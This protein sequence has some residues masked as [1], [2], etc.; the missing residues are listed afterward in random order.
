MKTHD[1]TPE[2]P[3]RRRRL[4]IATANGAK[5]REFRRMLGDDAY[6]WED[7]NSLASVEPPEET[8]DTFEANARLKAAYYA[9]HAGMHALADDSGLEVDAL[10]GH[11]GVYS[12]RWAEIHHTGRG[13]ADN[14][15]LLLNQ[16][17]NVADDQRTARFV[18]VLAL[19]DE[20]GA[21]LRIQRGQVE[22]KILRAPRGQNGFG[23]DP[24]FFI[25]ELG[26][27]TAELSPDEKNRISHRGRALRA[28]RKEG[29]GISDQGIFF[30]PNS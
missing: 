30:N 14:N 5:V 26:K 10:Q 29:L 9:R 3:V 22:G 15:E 2:T 16:L 8:G 23:Y 17:R 20:N 12:A 19:A 7:L 21:I 27:T 13:D 25:P 18:C 28:M 11:P 4:L 6:Q 24:L 1:K